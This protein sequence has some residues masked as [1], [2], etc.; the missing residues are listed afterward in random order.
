MSVIDTREIAPGVEIPVLGLGTW[1]MGGRQ[2]EDHRWDEENVTAIRM[3]IELGLIHID[4]AEYYGAGHS[5]ELVGEAVDLDDDEPTPLILRDA[6]P[7]QATSHRAVLA[8]VICIGNHTEGIEHALCKPSGHWDSSASSTASISDWR[9][10]VTHLIVS[11][12]VW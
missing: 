3:A 11:E 12:S 9:R 10:F 4:T 7:A 1:G 6:R 5:E 2:I 8:R